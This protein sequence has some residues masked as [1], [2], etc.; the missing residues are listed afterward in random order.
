[1]FRTAIE[2]LA[3]IATIVG[4]TIAVLPSKQDRTASASEVC[5]GQTVAD[6][7]KVQTPRRSVPVSKSYQ[8]AKTAPVQPTEEIRKGSA[9]H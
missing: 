1:M 3:G 6:S 9:R 5:P 8:N 4:T 7:P 2:I